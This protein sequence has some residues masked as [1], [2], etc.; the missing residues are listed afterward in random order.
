MRCCEVV[1]GSALAANELSFDECSERFCMEV[2]FILRPSGGVKRGF[3]LA[4]FSCT[5]AGLP[6]RCQTPDPGNIV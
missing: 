6:Y 4:D 2:G 3:L 1:D 5:A